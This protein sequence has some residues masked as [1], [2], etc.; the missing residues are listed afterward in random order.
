MFEGFS[1]EYAP[2]VANKLTK[3]FSIYPDIFFGKEVNVK[4]L[5]GA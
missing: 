5:A 3:M 4:L 2:L 1:N